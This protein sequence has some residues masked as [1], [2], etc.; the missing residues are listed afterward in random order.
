[1]PLYE[2]QCPKDGRFEVIRKFSD[3]PLTIC[4]T[5][6]SEIQKLASAPAIQFK[7]TG[8]YI[9]DYAR[10]S[11]GD[12]KSGEIARPAEQ[13]DR[14]TSKAGEGKGE[15][16][17]RASPATASRSP[18]TPPRRT[19]A[20]PAKKSGTRA[21]A[22]SGTRGRAAQVLAL[23]RELHRGLQ[24]AELVAG[25]VAHALEA[26]AVDRPLVAR[27]ARMPLVSWISP[28]VVARRLLERLEDVG[29]E[30]VAADDGQVAG[31]LLGL[32]LLHQVA[33]AVDAVARR[34]PASPSITP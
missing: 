9:T 31:R 15:I 34:P 16:R 8:W 14:A 29:G 32:R 12:A 33:D 26:I 1:M 7:G 18:R 25:V 20:A 22:P 11:S 2:Y 21:S 3:P 4:P 19:A 13:Q 24:E 17:R 23:Q 10:K 6:G 28:P 30:D 5:C 27:G